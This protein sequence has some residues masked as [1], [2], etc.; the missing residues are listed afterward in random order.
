MVVNLAA[1]GV[2]DSEV[3]PA[4]HALLEDSGRHVART[5]V[6]PPGMER[7]IEEDEVRSSADLRI[8]KSQVGLALV[9]QASGS[10]FL[11][12]PPTPNLG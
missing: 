2:C 10:V 1:R 11:F 12:L 5:P 3:C 7:H 8:R 9:Q 4:R 6:S